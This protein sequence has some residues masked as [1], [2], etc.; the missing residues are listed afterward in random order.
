MGKS[1]AESRVLL[2]IMVGVSILF[3]FM[4]AGY[5]LIFLLASLGW[6][7]QLLL[8]IISAYFLKIVG[9]IRI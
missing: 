8:I 9:L 6:S 1:F 7:W 4:L 2:N 3:N 5:G